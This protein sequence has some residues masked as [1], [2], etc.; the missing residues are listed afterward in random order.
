[1]RAS[2][3]SFNLSFLGNEFSKILADFF[4][5]TSFKKMKDIYDQSKYQKVEMKP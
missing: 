4:T 2:D 5:M 1:M 3:Q